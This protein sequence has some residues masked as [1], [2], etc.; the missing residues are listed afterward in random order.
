M[1]T[2]KQFKLR[3]GKTV[4][5]HQHQQLEDKT[6]WPHQ[7]LQLKDKTA[8]K[9]KK[10]NRRNNCFSDHCYYTLVARTTTSAAIATEAVPVAETRTTTTSSTTNLTFSHRQQE[11]SGYIMKIL[12]KVHW[13]IC[14][15]FELVLC[16]KVVFCVVTKLF[17]GSQV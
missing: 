1:W 11:Q 3:I 16:K 5:P 4:W 6:V 7:H 8:A 14:K 12:N 10:G 2:L 13:N 17:Q 9:R 15:E